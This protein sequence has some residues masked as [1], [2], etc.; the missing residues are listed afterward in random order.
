LIALEAVPVSDSASRDSMTVVVDGRLAGERLHFERSG[1]TYRALGAI[2][3]DAGDAAR[4]N[5]AVRRAGGDADVA[6]AVPVSRRVVRRERLRAADRFVR[7]PDSALA[8]RLARERA[9]VAGVLKDTHDRPRFWGE[10]WQR[11]LGGRVLSGFGVARTF[12]NVVES[13][14]RGVDLAA[15]LGDSVFAANRGVIVIVADH[16]YAGK[17]VWVDHGAGLLTAYLHLSRA[18]VAVG[19]TIER[20]QLLGLVGN[21]G[22]VTAPH[23]HWSALY[24][25]IGVDPL[26]L[27][28]PAVH[29]LT[30]TAVAADTAGRN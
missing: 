15:A 24:G 29:Q 16:Y 20:A 3:L 17:S 13:R 30:E 12:N 10:A 26:D 19:D 9:Q 14:H 8:A 6:L 11:P 5:V 1:G 7:P 27:L 25:G 28:G 2:P 23:L 22:R 18:A 4:G 21:S